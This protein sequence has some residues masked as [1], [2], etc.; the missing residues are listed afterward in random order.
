MFFV[1]SFEESFSLRSELLIKNEFFIDV[2][3]L[4]LSIHLLT[5]VHKEHI[6]DLSRAEIDLSTK[7]ICISSITLEKYS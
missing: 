1:F 6:L 4:V 7:R 2:S 3:F 5:L